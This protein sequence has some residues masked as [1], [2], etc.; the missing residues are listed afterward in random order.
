MKPAHLR[1]LARLVRP[2]DRDAVAGDW[3]EGYH[4]CLGRRGSMAAKLWLAGQVLQYLPRSANRRI[5]HGG[6]RR[7]WTL[8]WRHQRRQPLYAVLTWTSLAVG[9]W[10]ALAIALFIH[11]ELGYERHIP[12]AD[13]IYRVTMSIQITDVYRPHW[14]R[15]AF[16]GL[17]T[18]ADDI[19]E[20]ESIVRFSQLQT[21][22]VAQG[23]KVFSTAA[24]F[25]DPNVFE[26][27]GYTL[28]HGDPA[29]ALVEPRNVV[30]TRSKALAL[31]GK[32]DVVGESLAIAPLDGSSKTVYRI[33]GV[34]ADLPA[35]THLPIDYLF[36]RSKAIPSGAW[37]YTYVLLRDGASPQ[38]VAEKLPDFVSHYTDAKTF[39]LT[40]QPLTGIHLDSHLD[41]ELEANGDR[42][43]LTLFA[44]IGVLVL[45]LAGMNF[46]NLTTARVQHRLR[47][48]GLAKVLGASRMRILLGGF[49]EALFTAGL[50]LVLAALVLA[51]TLPLFNA[52]TGKALDLGDLIQPWL[53]G[54]AVLMALV[55]GL[56]AGLYPAIRLAACRPV[57]ALLGKRS[58]QG[59]WFRK[60]LVVFQ[61]AVSLGLIIMAGVVRLQSRFV[62]DHRLQTLGSPVLAVTPLPFS[63][64]NDL[65][66]FT[67]R[68]RAE[69]S[70][71]A[72]A[73]SME[74]PSRETLD[75]GYVTA[76]GIESDP[77]NPL[78]IYAMPVDQAFYGFYNLKLVAG[79]FP[80]Q[81]AP[82]QEKIEYLLNETSVKA[83][84]W[85][86]PEDAI[87][88]RFRWDQSGS[89][90]ESVVI[91]VVQ[92][93]HFST[94]K[95]KIK[96]LVFVQKN[97]WLGCLLFRPRPGQD[98]ESLHAAR[99]IFSEYAPDYPF[100][101]ESVDGLYRQLYTP[102]QRLARLIDAL[103]LIA[104]L[105]GALGLVGLASHAARERMREMAIRKVLGADAW[106]LS[107]LFARDLLAS[108][109]WANALAWPVAWWAASQWLQG[110]AYRI[111]LPWALFPLA[112]G[113]LLLVGLVASGQPVAAALRQ[114]P[115]R[116]LRLE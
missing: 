81:S 88:R 89:L 82:G 102:E 55:I 107:K 57:E 67:Q 25:V 63:I 8:W 116:T 5:G 94:L 14:A 71:E 30:L 114:P 42:Q 12:L 46:V 47:E 97:I 64:R 62:L 75:G 28:I 95:K 22:L 79:R 85:S 65:D 31:F 74:P 32:E 16:E 4:E 58:R 19:P 76:E 51:A 2:A 77:E 45:I 21:G 61:F 23:R 29:T 100:Q 69:P 98:A 35:Q 20:V 34:M 66:R 115:A 80:E 83:I 52:I 73:A 11:D 99:A 54:G 38:T 13:R 108:L 103:G 56:L 96:P 109:V 72:V 43:L 41:R 93:F 92:D 24:F 9:F 37:A 104:V 106:R 112:G 48:V 59:A 18:L 91:G 39:S 86:S 6:T 105:I 101:Y 7:Q 78:L 36:T 68:L 10:V 113:A 84:G 26:V 33:T 49:W 70:I 40:I 15:C 17:E 27:F 90:P 44:L 3:I 1:F 111:D 87:G 50:A 60:I 110:F 53:G